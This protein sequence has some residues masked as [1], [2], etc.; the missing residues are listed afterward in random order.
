VAGTPRTTSCASSAQCTTTLAA[1][2]LQLAGNLP[3]QLQ[4][5]DGTL[6]N[7][8]TFVALSSGSGAATIAL[9]PSAPISA[10]NDIV[11]V[12]L[13]SNGGSDGG[14]SASLNVAAIGAYS[15]STSSCVLAGSPVI[16]QR[17]STGTGTADLCVFSGSGLDPSFAYTISG[18]PTPDITVSA[19]TA[20]SLGIMHVT[21]QVP[22]SAA[23]GPRTLFVENPEGDK[24]AGTGAIEVR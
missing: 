20:L 13:S 17:P 15:V 11:V 2:D 8:L 22:A 24:A 14:G 3:I 1:S 23:P 18:P 16:V 10:G 21:L 9:T 6:S 19:I 12:E 7:V 4:N 5:P